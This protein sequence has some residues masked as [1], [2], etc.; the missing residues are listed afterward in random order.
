[1][2]HTF[3][4]YESTIYGGLNVGDNLMVSDNIYANSGQLVLTELTAYN[5]T[6][7]NTKLAGILTPSKI[8]ITGDGWSQIKIRSNSDTASSPAEIGFSRLVK[9][10]FL[11]G[12]IGVSGDTTRGAFWYAGGYDRINID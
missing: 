12:A 9:K 5:K 3:R 7:I 6:E 11:E 1:M 4:E 2:R 10:Q 8:E